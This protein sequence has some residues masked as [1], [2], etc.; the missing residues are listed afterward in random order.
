MK[1]KT[2]LNQIVAQYEEFWQGTNDKPLLNLSYTDNKKD[3]NNFIK[4]WMP[5]EYGWSMAVAYEK[6]LKTGEISYVTEA[7]DYYEAEIDNVECCASGFKRYWYNL[8]PGVVAS[9]ISGF[10]KFA[11]HSV[12]FELDS[13]MSFN[14][15]RTYH[16]DYINEYGK[17]ALEIA[18]VIVDRFKDKIIIAQTDLGGVVD[19]LA[20]LRRTEQLLFDCIDNPE[21]IKT[22]LPVIESIW[23]EY[24]L[25]FDRI[26]AEANKG[27]RSSWIPLLSKQP[28]YPLQCDFCY[29]LSPEIF[30]DIV[31]PSLKR[32]AL[33]LK[34]AV[35]HLD[36][37]GELPFIDMLCSIPEIK[38]I[39]WTAGAGEKPEWDEKW[40]S[41]YKKIIDKGKKVFLFFHHDKELVKRLFSKLPSKE[42]CLSI[43][44][45]DY[46]TASDIEQLNYY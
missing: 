1:S 7:L 16:S 45:P 40:F 23:R 39:Q 6:F 38:V 42:F 24:F 36:G 12:W 13:S 32:D 31:F 28:F 2:E 22:S 15:I 43:H 41:L 37:P 44:A 29:M 9:F 20:S 11:Q 4:P 5:S 34:R 30:E 10:F 46:K 3:I 25:R 17:K 21:E 26:F 8:G 35:Y 18:K 27:L 19:I 33:F 14:K